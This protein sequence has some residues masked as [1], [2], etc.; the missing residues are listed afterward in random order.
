MNN[1]SY[2]GAGY[3][4]SAIHKTGKGPYWIVVDEGFGKPGHMLRKNIRSL[5]EAKRVV[6]KV[7]PEQVFGNN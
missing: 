2:G 7:T 5:D 1:P 6:L 3:G 4:T